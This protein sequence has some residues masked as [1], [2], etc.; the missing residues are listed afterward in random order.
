MGDIVNHG[1]D[2]ETPALYI[3]CQ[4]RQILLISR[5]QDVLR[6]HVKY[7]NYKLHGRIGRGNSVDRSWKGVPDSVKLIFRDQ[8]T[9]RN[10]HPTPRQLADETPLSKVT[11]R[12]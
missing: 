7:V 5:I 9:Q 4:G 8:L 11:G 1:C 12:I 3:V 10:H 6:R 2:V